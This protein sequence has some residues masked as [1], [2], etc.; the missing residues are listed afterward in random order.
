MFE[1][2]LNVIETEKSYNNNVV[3]CTSSEKTSR[4]LHELVVAI[5]AVS[6]FLDIADDFV[7]QQVHTYG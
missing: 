5:R 4:S 3:E 2:C 7:L 1:L 6:D